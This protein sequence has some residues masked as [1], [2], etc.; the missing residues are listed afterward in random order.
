MKSPKRD[1]VRYMYVYKKGEIL[2][3]KFISEK[4]VPSYIIYTKLSLIELSFGLR[5]MQV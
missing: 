2:D 5:N 3:F 1:L 4:T